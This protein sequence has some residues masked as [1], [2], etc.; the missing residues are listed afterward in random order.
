MQLRKDPQKNVLLLSLKTHTLVCLP[1]IT[2]EE[3][4]RVINRLREGEKRYTELYNTDKNAHT[5]HNLELY[6]V[7]C[8]FQIT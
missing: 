1:A 5:K 2:Q 8:M 3:F 7:N 4:T 6:L